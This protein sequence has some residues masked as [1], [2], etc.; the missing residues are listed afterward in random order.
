VGRQTEMMWVMSCHPKAVFP[1]EF[2]RKR[3]A[4]PNRSPV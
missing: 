2:F 4:T 1:E 3:S